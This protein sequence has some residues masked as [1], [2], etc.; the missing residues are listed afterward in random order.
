MAE[1]VELQFGTTTAWRL[2]ARLRS[3]PDMWYDCRLPQN[4]EP[5]VRPATHRGTLEGEGYR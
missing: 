4:E 2:G 5:K 1:L 3:H